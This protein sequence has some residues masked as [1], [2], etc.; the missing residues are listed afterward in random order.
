MK[1]V[2]ER[3]D[4]GAVG[5]KL[6]LR[7]INKVPRERA[8]NDYGYEICVGC[9]FQ[10]DEEPDAFCAIEDVLECKEGDIWVR[11]TK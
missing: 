10:V 6:K 1:L 5:N 7:R 2:E 9:I 4:M 8:F 11:K 3:A